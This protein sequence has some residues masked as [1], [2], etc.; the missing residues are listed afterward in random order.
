MG[1]KTAQSCANLRPDLVLRSTFFG[2][3][4]GEERDDL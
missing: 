2:A 3:V 1:V 4:P